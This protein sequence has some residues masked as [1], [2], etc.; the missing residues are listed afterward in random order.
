MI[1]AI[2][3]CHHWDLT[4]T[5]KA[6]LYR[7]DCNQTGQWSSS[8][9]E[10][11]KKCSLFDFRVHAA[12]LIEPPNDAPI[13]YAQRSIQLRSHP[14]KPRPRGILLNSNLPSESNPSA[15]P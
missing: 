7:N 12:P 13:L 1:T 2:K 14:L 9:L 5:R 3:N 15:R 11:P 10:E 6:Y 8:L 4:I